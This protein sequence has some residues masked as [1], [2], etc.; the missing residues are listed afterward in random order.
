[1][2]ASPI[3]TQAVITRDNGRVI[4]VNAPASSA[5]NQYVSALAVNGVGQSRTWL[6]ESFVANGGTV[7][8]TMTGSPTSW[9]TGAADAPPSFSDGQNGFNNIGTSN[10]GS[11]NTANLDSSGHSYSAQALAAAGIQPGGTVSANGM[12][13]TW[14]SAAAGKPNNWLVNAR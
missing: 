6:P 3:F 14:P 11:A 8:F 13:F 12:S 9:G 10:D 1:M 2:L 4:T 7:D 5:G